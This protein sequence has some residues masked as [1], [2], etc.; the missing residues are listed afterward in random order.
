MSENGRRILGLLL[1]I[2][3][4]AGCSEG[5]ELGEV[6]GTVSMGGKP[7]PFAYVV[8]QP[9][10]PPGTYGSAYTLIDGTYEIQ[11]SQS[12]SGAMVGQHKVSIRTAGLDEVEVED[13][14]TGLMKKPD[15]PEGYKAGLE[16]EFDREVRSG[17]NVH[18]FELPAGGK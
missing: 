9:V 3:A 17:G 11:F 14:K 2:G 18:D 1:M 8:F 10:D 12:R 6:S 5:P 16:L 7:I 13:K 15:L 4:A